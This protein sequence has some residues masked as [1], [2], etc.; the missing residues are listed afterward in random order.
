MLYRV[1]TTGQP[2]AR[3]TEPLSH[4]ARTLKK[5]RR[6][7]QDAPV[8]T[9]LDLVAAVSDS[10]K[11]ETEVIATVTHLINSGKIRLVGNFQGAD[12]RVG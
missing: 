9:L 1:K 4:A 8:T 5:L 10:A 12:V 6:R 3:R 11:S 7:H 2:I